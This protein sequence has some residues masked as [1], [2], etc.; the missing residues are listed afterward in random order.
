[1]SKKQ[2]VQIRSLHMTFR[3]SGAPALEVDADAVL[4]TPRDKAAYHRSIRGKDARAL[5]DELLDKV[6]T[7]FGSRDFI[8]VRVEGE[9]IH[10]DAEA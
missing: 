5:A 4:T 2:T 3:F 7:A 6:K 8:D 1:M 9:E 10:G